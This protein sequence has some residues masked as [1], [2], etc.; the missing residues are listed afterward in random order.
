MYLTSLINKKKQ[1]CADSTVQL[2]E[3][4]ACVSKQISS[5]LH[6]FLNYFYTLV[7]ATIWFYLVIVDFFILDCS[8][9]N[10]L[11]RG[12]F[13]NHTLLKIGKKYEI[14]CKI[15]F[16]LLLQISL[17]V[18]K[19]SIGRKTKA[20]GVIAP[21]SLRYITRLVCGNNCCRGFPFWAFHAILS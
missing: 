10:A 20:I 9:T 1:K 13:E 21:G 12:V 4:F 15:L 6:E 14:Y 18:A 7:C 5:L 11:D 2:I 17:A 3:D 8:T 16:V 19:L